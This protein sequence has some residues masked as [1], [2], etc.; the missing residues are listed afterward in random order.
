MAAKPRE[1]R[2]RM[3]YTDEGGDKTQVYESTVQRLKHIAEHKP[4][5]RLEVPNSWKARHIRELQDQGYIEVRWLE[6][7]DTARE[8]AWDVIDVTDFG[9]KI[10]RAWDKRAAKKQ[11]GEGAA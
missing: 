3:V 8:G 6:R 11:E 4:V 7:G 5:G 10:I 2:D 1:P 9:H